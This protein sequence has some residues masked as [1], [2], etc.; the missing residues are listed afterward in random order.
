MGSREFR[1]DVAWYQNTYAFLWGS[2]PKLENSQGA[3]R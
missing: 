3:R 1:K 2:L